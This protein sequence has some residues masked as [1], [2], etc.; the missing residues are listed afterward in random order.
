MTTTIRNP[1]PADR[2]AWGALY[3]G[4]AEFYKT[5]Q[6]AEMR[7]VVWSWLLDPANPEEALVAEAPDGTLVGLAHFRP[8]PRPL[9]A[10]TC[11]YLDDLFV[12]PSYRGS[13]VADE[14]LTRLRGIALERGWEMVRWTTADD[15]YR[16]RGKYDQ[17]ATRTTWITYDM[18][19]APPADPVQKR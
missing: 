15:N 17:V 8:Y 2:D 3:A 11:G 7:D 12:D 10:S 14:L 5:E 1:K 6:S 16:A 9:H 19:V 13:G 18:P 4:Y